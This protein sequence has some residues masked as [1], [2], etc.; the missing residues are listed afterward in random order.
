[1]RILAMIALVM[2]LLLQG[3]LVAYGTVSDGYGGHYAWTLSTAWW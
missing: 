3:C 2:M 1:M